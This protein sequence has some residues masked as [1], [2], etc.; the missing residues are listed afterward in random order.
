M[1]VEDSAIRPIEHEQGF[2]IFLR[3]LALGAEFHTR[4]RTDADIDSR[5]EAVGVI[6]GPIGAAGTPAKFGARHA[7]I[8]PRRPVPWQAP[9]PFHV[10]VEGEHLAVSIEVEVVGV[11]EAG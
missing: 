1:Y 11:A 9:V 2:A 5:W 10:A 8:N 3:K 6:L 4:G 7:M